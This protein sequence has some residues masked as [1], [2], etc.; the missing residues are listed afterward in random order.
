M[1]S[2]PQD[3][4]TDVTLGVCLFGGVKLSKYADPDKYSY[5]GYSIGFDTQIEYS[6]LDGS[7][8]KNVFIFGADISSKVHIDNKGKSTLILGKG[9]TQELDHTLAAETQYLVN[10]TR[11][12]IKV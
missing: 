12:G 1:D 4:N 6:L 8:S 11:P 2:W 9:P 3:L 10:F 5:S 7:V